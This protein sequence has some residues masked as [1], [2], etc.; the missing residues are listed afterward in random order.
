MRS[1]MMSKW[2]WYVRCQ[3]CGE[4]L[5]VGAIGLVCP[6]GHGRIVRNGYKRQ[7]ESFPELV[8]EHDVPQEERKA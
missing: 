4:P 1:D 5:L 6:N 8:I 3:Q 7:R 2:R